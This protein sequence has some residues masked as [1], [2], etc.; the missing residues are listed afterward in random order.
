MKK[1]VFIDRDGIINHE[2]GHYTCKV[3]DF[4]INDGVG[5]TIDLLKKNDFLVIVISNQ[6]GIAKQLYTENDVLE[7][8]IKLCEY[9]AGYNTQVDDFYFCPHHDEFGKCLCRKPQA[10][11]LEKAMAVYNIDAVK[12]FMIG[13]SPRDV[14]A[15]KRCGVKGI[16]VKS[17]QNI[18]QTCVDIVNGS[19]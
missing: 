16:L 2:P 3:D 9:L 11:M 12:S 7:M 15:A 19:L 13:D 1:A 4:I 5:E 8:H 18:Y 6:G 14:E 17:N 10:L